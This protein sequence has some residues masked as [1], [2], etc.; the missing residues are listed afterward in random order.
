MSAHQP[1]DP[2]AT[3]TYEYDLPSELV[4]QAPAP[5]RE[6]AR[7]LWLP[8]GGA[9]QHRT[10]AELPSLLRPGD[11]LVA[12]DTRVLRARFFPKRRRGGAS[13]VLLLHPATKAGTWIAM[14]RPGKRVR[15]GDRLSLGPAEGIEILDWAPGGNRLV[16]FYGID[17][18]AAMERYGIV[19]LPPY[20][21]TPPVDAAERYQTVYAAREGSVAA[22]T[23]GLHFTSELI[24]ALRAQGVAWHTITL[25]VGAGTFRPVAAVDIREHHMHEERYD[26]P[27]ATAQ[28][29]GQTRRSGGRVIAVG[30][31]TLRALEDAARQSTDGSIDAGSRWT[32]LFIHPPM[33]ITTADALIT[34]FHLPR[35]TL[36][37]L[38]CAFA[39]TRRVLDAYREAVDQ[40]YRFY[41]FGDAMLVE[42]AEV[43]ASA[44]ARAPY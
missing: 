3:A 27:D 10:F 29:I 26:I 31:T 32:S 37:M 30:T 44:D 2:Y 15:P 4:A 42:R 5:S 18:Q 19:P 34:N 13:Q 23:A 7:L 6:Q 35:S 14:A 24:E 40:Q 39:G 25:D 20:V 11:L 21:R 8:H 43:T 33:Q 1:T 22:P 12:N 16:Q 28:A 38:V 41:S 17:A 9:T 36:L